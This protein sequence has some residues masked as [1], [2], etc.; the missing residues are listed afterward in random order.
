MTAT[1]IRNH[2]Q[3]LNYLV[4]KYNLKSYLEIGTQRAENNFIK[5]NADFKVGVDPEPVTIVDGIVKMK[6]DD[7]FKSRDE[8]KIHQRTFDLVFIDGLHHADQVKRDFEN[9]L[10]CLNDGGFIVIHDTLPEDESTTHVPRDS[11]I[12]HG[13][14]YKFCLNIN[15]YQGIDFATVN[16]DCGCMVIWKDENRNHELWA[17]FGDSWDAYQKHRHQKMK[18]I[19]PDEIEKYF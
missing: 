5:I 2:T 1:A 6:S 18:I 14:V 8:N 3:L 12:W 10:R 15:R 9:S 7:Y 13:D 11:K 4:E 17:D 19:Q 16:M